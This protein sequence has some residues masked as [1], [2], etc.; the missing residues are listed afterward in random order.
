MP[1]EI[2]PPVDAVRLIEVLI[3]EDNEMDLIWT[4]TALRDARVPNHISVV[5]DGERA[6]A[7]LRR[8]G[9]YADAPAPDIVFLDLRLPRV[10]GHQ[11]LAEMKA[12]PRLRSI[13]VVVVSGSR[14]EADVARAYEKQVAG[15]IVKGASRDDYLTAI[16][17][18]KELWFHNVV[19]P[20]KRAGSAS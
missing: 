14:A 1:A 20:S 16:R 3:V 13:P 4:S 12:D 5:C 9:E 2:T 8:E 11:V 10:S 15:Y 7:F 17:A 19:L 18:V 6:L